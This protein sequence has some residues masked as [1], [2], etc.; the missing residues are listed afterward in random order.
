MAGA[1]RTLYWIAP[2]TH[3]IITQSFATTVT[4]TSCYSISPQNSFKHINCKVRLFIVF[5]ISA[6]LL[7]SSPTVIVGFWAGTKIKINLLRQLN[8]IV[9]KRVENQIAPDCHSSC[10]LIL[11]PRPTQY[12]CRWEILLTLY[13]DLDAGRE[14]GRGVL[15]GSARADCKC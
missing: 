7:W 15:F 1:K 6:Q 14:G 2:V 11:R 10:L 12:I 5:N 4:F 13:L 9:S 3:T 8:T